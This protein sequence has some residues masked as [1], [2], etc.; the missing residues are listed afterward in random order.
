MDKSTIVIGAGLS[1]L[2][3]ALL[4]A[5]SGRRV[6]L[7]EQHASPAPVVSGFRRAGLY[8]DS[9]FHYAGGLGAGGPLGPLLRHLGLEQKLQ[10][11]PYAAD[12]FDCLRLAESGDEY[13]LPVGFA[14]IENELGSRFPAARVELT[15][16]LDEV[17]ASWR[18]FPYLDLERELSDFGLATVHGCSLQQRLQVFA[19]WPELQSLLSMHCLLYGVPPADAPQS[20]NA[21]VAGSYYHS[22]HGI[23]G[24]GRSLVAAFVELAE[25]AGVEIRC[26][27][28]VRRIRATN[29]AVAGVE[30]ATGERLAAQE[31]V[32]TLN[33]AQLPE[34]LPEAGLRPAYLNRLRALRQTPSACILFA[35][36]QGSLEFL[37]GR[38]LFLQPRAGLCDPVVALP[39]EE[40]PCYLAA[41]DQGGADELKGLIA[42]VPA[43]YAEVSA[44]QDLPR[45][46]NDAYRA[47]KAQLTTRLL[48]HLQRSCPQLPELEALELATPL[49]L[50][51][52]SCA[53][54]G[55]I[56]GV[57]RWLGQYN[58]HPATRL[59]G[60]YLSG[61][62]VTAPGLLGTLV[63]AYL[64]CG[65]IL[66]HEQL[67]GELRR[68]R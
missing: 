56:Y 64:T 48:E 49:S 23:V 42:I 65:T 58:P 9:G 13:A 53:P 60:F 43:H 40:R 38:N 39:L 6:Q 47:W 2:S 54:E 67:R 55:A 62:A 30:L 35:R 29:R 61:Q 1:G 7:L 26:S 36:S 4:L 46:R 34:L 45:R 28:E 68:C 10:L 5:R 8:F 57:G 15:R 52:Y 14:N 19:P 21:Q 51:D 3:C 37:R 50:R 59:A 25:A 44:W 20:L 16:Y 27:A 18:N 17:A 33:P 11:F 41:A 32:A 31:V 63:A 24:G 22:V 12:G 66:G